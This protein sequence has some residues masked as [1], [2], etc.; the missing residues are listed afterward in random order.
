MNCFIILVDPP[1]SF[2]TEICVNC[3]R[4]KIQI[5][6][7]YIQIHIH[8]TGYHHRNHRKLI[9]RNC[10]LYLSM[11]SVVKCL[12][13]LTSLLEIKQFN[14]AAF[15]LKYYSRGCNNKVNHFENLELNKRHDSLYK[16]STYYNRVDNII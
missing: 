7:S 13:E 11:S 10:C 9:R 16:K 4:I 2:F 12:K 3:L 14:T 15:I 8:V 5:K 6:Y 1:E